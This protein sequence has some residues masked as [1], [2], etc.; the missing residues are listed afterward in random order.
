LCILKP[1]ENYKN[2]LPLDLDNFHQWKC[3]ISYVTLL[4]KKFH[5]ELCQ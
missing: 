2:E 3:D 5:I 1:S 4:D